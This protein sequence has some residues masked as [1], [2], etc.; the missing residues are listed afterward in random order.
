MTTP[1]TH[2]SNSAEFADY[3]NDFGVVA[4]AEE[5]IVDAQRGLRGV[6]RDGRVGLALSGG[7]IRSASFALGV[8]QALQ[9]HS[10]FRLIDYLSTVSGGGYIGS[11]LSW[12]MRD[13]RKD[14][15]FGTKGLGVRSDDS[16]SPSG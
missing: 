1:Q 14:F 4:G 2:E 7:G 15:P 8:L 3:T 11:S 12:F 6:A 5:Q 16:L 13:G 9:R 10:L